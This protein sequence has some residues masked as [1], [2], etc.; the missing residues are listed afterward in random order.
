MKHERPVELLVIGV[1]PGDPKQITVEAIEAMGRLDAVVLLDK[2]ESTDSMRRLRTELLDRYA[3]GC[4]VLTVSDP[5]RDR[6]PADYGAEVRR[7]HDARVEAI[8]AVLPRSGAVGFLVWGDPSL[9]DST[10]RIV[11]ALRRLPGRDVAVTVIPGV[12]SASALTAAHAITANRI[13]E[14]VHITTGRRLPD[15]PEAVRGNQIVMLDGH[16]A[17]RTAA[18]PGDEIYWA[19]NL[20]TDDEVLIAGPVDE[21][22]EAIGEARADLKRRVGWA[23]DIYLLRSPD[24]P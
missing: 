21:V 6:R 1:G 17:F 10:L 8:A 14:P 18:R 13:G 4:A 20:G 19:A 7:W 22:A 2:G 5:P 23:M 11:D 12:T 16:E 15:T 24:A 3:P 9:Y